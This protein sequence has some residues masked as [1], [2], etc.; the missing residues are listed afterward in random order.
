MPF[1]LP[2]QQCQSTE[3]NSKHSCQ[4][5]K[6]LTVLSRLTDS[7]RKGCWLSTLPVHINLFWYTGITLL[8]FV[9]FMCNSFGDI[10]NNMLTCLSVLGDYVYS[11]N[12]GEREED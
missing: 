1:L 4:L 2:S 3:A 12:A 7:V 8:I 6:F 11:Y 10:E 5:R 9:E